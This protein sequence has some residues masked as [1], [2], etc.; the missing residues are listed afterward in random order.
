[1]KNKSLNKHTNALADYLPN[2]RLFAAKRIKDSNFRQLLK[3]I[4]GEIFNAQGYIITLEDEYFP[5]LTTLFLEE[6]ERALGIPDD[7]FSGVGTII[8]RRR[9]ILVKLSALGVQTVS[10]FEQLALLFGKIV[11][12]TPLIDELFPPLPV[13]FNPSATTEGR[14]TVVVTGVDLVSGIP[15][16]DVPFDLLRDAS[17]LECLFNKQ[18]PSNCNVIF[19]NS[20]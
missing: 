20:N 8:E 17:I 6:W 7:C 1:M 4:A 10:D 12:V 5:D 18:I 15:P 19:R 14:F 11:T 2:G 3:G 13:P 9:D 16:Y